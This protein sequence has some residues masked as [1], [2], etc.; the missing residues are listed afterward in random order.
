MNFEKEWLK[1]LKLE[2]KFSMYKILQKKIYFDQIIVAFQFIFLYLWIVFPFLKGHNCQ[3]LETHT[4]THIFVKVCC[5]Q[6]RC[7]PS[8]DVALELL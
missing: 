7:E 4:K 3:L 2:A 5:S 6:L 8:L 1:P